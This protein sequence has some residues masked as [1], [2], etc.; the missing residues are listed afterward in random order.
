MDDRI[1]I[2]P[3]VLLITSGCDKVTDPYD[4]PGSGGG[5]TSSVVQRRV[6]L[7]DFTGFRCNNC[8][9]ATQVAL[10]L[11]QVYGEDRLMVVGVH[12]MPFFSNPI[13][14][15]GD[16]YFDTDFQTPE[17]NAYVTTFGITFLPT[18][19][20]SRREYNSSLTLG[21]ASWGSAVDEIIGTPADVDLLFSSF[22]LDGTNTIHTTVQ[23]PVIHDVSGD[24]NLTVYLTEDHVDDWQIDNQQTPSEVEHYDHRHVLRDNLNGAWGDPIISGS[25]AAGDTLTADL[26]RALAAGVI[27]PDNCALI[28]YLYNTATYEII[29]VSEHKFLP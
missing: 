20:V 12:G 17:A 2:L 6:L 1:R 5:D 23:V 16:G 19:M 3:L 22:E 13:P 8:P 26:S 18:G 29:Q 15:A 4:G 25:A 14:P 11:Q 28:A 9:A 27:D 21:E 7:E 24:Y 10:Q